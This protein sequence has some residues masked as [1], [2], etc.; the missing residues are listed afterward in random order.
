MKK[1]FVLITALILSACSQP[2]PQEQVQQT[3]KEIVTAI[4]NGEKQLLL[5]KY[6]DMGKYNITAKDLQQENLDR[7]KEV[8]VKAENQAPEMN[9]DN[10]RAEIAVEGM[11]KPLTFTKAEDGQWKLNN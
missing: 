7:L 10:T 8:L 4:D 2:T 3:M 6:V 1:F 9:E 5:D 11:H